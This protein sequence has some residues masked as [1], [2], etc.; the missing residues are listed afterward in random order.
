MVQTSRASQQDAALGP[1]D[2]PG[3]V[4]APP[5][6]LEQPV[7]LQPGEA[8]R[9]CLPR[10]NSVDRGLQPPKCQV[11]QDN[12][13]L[14]KPGGFRELRGPDGLGWGVTHFAGTEIAGGGC[15]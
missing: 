9:L 10:W 6:P 4:G 15:R 13:G 7:N 1:L 5:V 11:L 12:A 2:T 14:S 3:P 8:T